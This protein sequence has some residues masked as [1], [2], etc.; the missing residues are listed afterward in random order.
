MRTAATSSGGLTAMPVRKRHHVIS[1]VHGRWTEHFDEEQLREDC[2][3]WI[4]AYVRTRPVID[5]IRVR[6]LVFVTVELSS[7][8]EDPLRMQHASDLVC[9][10]LVRKASRYGLVDASQSSPVSNNNDRDHD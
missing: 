9:E 6:R 2:A 4:A 5:V 1:V 7:T 3:R 8:T 10:N